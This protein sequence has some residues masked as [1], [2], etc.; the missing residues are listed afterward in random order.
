VA[1][2]VAIGLQA[3]PDSLTEVFRVYDSRSLKRVL[4]GKKTYIYYNGKM[5]I[6]GYPR[7][8]R[9]SID[10]KTDIHG[11]GEKPVE[12]AERHEEVVGE[13]VKVEEEMAVGNVIE[14]SKEPLKPPTGGNP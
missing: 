7:P 5:K 11:F 2:V 4:S 1:A 13:Q 8:P 14:A 6:T 10:L 3:I 12:Q 9:K